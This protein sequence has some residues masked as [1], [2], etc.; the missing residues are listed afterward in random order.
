MTIQYFDDRDKKGFKA[1]KIKKKCP[2][3]NKTLHND[4][5]RHHIERIHRIEVFRY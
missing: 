2:Y 4:W 5:M 3:C 1:T